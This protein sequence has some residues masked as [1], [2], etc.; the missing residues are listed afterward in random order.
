[1]LHL[2]LFLVAVFSFIF[3]I[4]PNNQK[5]GKYNL[6]PGPKGLPLIGNLHQLDPLIRTPHISLFNLAK[7]YGPILSLQLGCRSTVVIQSAS[8]AKEVLKAQDHSFCNRPAMVAYRRLSYNGLDLAFAPYNEYYTEMRKICVVNLF[9]SKKVQSYAPIRREEVSRMMQKISSL[10]SASEIVNLSELVTA[11]TSS[12]ICRAAFGKSWLDKLSGLSSK[13]DRVFKDLDKFYDE[14]ISDHL[15]PNR[16]KDDDHHQ[17]IVDV[18]LQLQKEHC[19]SF[20]LTLDHIK[21]VLMNIILAGRDPSACMIVWAM[22]E[23][24]RNPM[25]MRK[26]QEELRTILQD[27]SFIEEEDLPKLEYFRAV[28][29]ETFRLQPTNP[30]L[31]LRET[32]EKCSI[33]GYDIL[34]KTSLVVNVWAIGRDSKSWNQPEAFM[35]ERFLRSPIDFKGRDFELIPFGAGRRI[36]PGMILGVATFE[37]ALANLL[38][39]FDWELPSGLKKEDIDYDVVP[40]I[41]MHKKNPLCLMAKKFSPKI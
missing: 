33:Q 10:S 28:V 13:L 9:S 16:L 40:G 37:I 38:Y 6:P 34:P 5:H 12:I 2:L 31:I 26:A 30:L 8:V 27:K 24:M 7:I 41:A 39:S 15:D 4:L 21:A 32:F 29:K 17:D 35:P 23:L 36:C 19:F 20:E 11:L 3:F 14:I 22:V 25:V 1:M 18:L